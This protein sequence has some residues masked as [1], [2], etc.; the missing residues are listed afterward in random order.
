MPTLGVTTDRDAGRTRIALS[1]ELDIANAERLETELASVEADAPAMLV[2]DLRQV[3]FMDSTG[4]RTV[5]AASERARTGGRRMVVVRGSAA[6]D[7]L[8]DITQVDQQLEIV[9]DPELIQ[10]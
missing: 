5:L 9:D 10:S 4:L 6:V 3:E 7:R 1:G 2:L 8:F